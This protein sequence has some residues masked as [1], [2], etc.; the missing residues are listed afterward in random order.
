MTARAAAVPV[1]ARRWFAGE[2]LLVRLAALAVL[3]PLYYAFDWMALRLAVRDAL[4][5]ILPLLGHPAFPVGSGPAAGILLSQGF[6][7]VTANCTYA[8]LMLTLAPFVWRFHRSAGANAAAL[9]LLVP[10][11]FVFNLARLVLAVELHARGLSWDRA[12]HLPDLGL[13]MTV[14]AVAV[15][16]ALRADHAPRS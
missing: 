9:A 14:I 5:A 3:L 8:D 7:E 13:H 10:A 4:A 16:L 11:V 15:L 6:F 1:L 12:H 2:P